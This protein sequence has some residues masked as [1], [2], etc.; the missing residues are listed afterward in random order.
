MRQKL[1][2][3]MVSNN[4]RCGWCKPNFANL[5]GKDLC[6]LRIGTPTFKNNW[7]VFELSW[8][9]SLI[10]SS[11]SQAEGEVTGWRRFHQVMLLIRRHGKR[12]PLK[13]PELGRRLERIG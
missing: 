3:P 9:A 1:V 5:V 2:K 4:R 6:G 12:N 7:V 8:R 11:S 10:F 13:D